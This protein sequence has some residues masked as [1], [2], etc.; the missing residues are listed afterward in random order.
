MSSLIEF[1]DQKGS[2]VITEEQFLFL[3]N[4]INYIPNF[5]IK[6]IKNLTGLT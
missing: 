1:L 5:Q 3:F 2:Q 6:P 4:T